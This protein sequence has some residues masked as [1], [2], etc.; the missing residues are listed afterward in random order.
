MAALKHTNFSK[1][2]SKLSEYS[3]SF[4]H[5]PSVISIE[6]CFYENLNKIFPQTFST[7]SEKFS[8]NPRL[9]FNSFYKGKVIVILSKN[10]LHRYSCKPAKDLLLIVSGS[11]I[12]FSSLR[13][14]WT[15]NKL[16]RQATFFSLCT[17]NTFINLIITFNL[18]QVYK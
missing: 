11:N 18:H 1:I 9:T 12:C 6:Y 3:L 8:K 13:H 10:F 4:L 15:C 16:I 17:L 5:K 7:I 14:L 2:L